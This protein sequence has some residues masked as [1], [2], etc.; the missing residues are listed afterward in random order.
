MIKKVKE[1]KIGS[2][3][4]GGSRPFALIAGVCVIE[5]EEHTMKIAAAL[6]E[7][8]GR[9]SVPLIFKASYDKAN[10]TS[11]SS[12]R[13]PGLGAGLRILED[14]KNELDVPVLTDC[15]REEDA[16]EVALM[17]DVI[18][19]PAF[20]CRQT[21]I[22]LAI[23]RTGRVVNVKKGQFLAPED[24][25]HIIKKIESTGNHNILLTER[26]IC[27]GYRNLIN[28]MR[29][30]PIMRGLGYPVVFDATH[31]VQLPGGGEGVT[32]GAREFIPYLARAAMGTGC[33]ALFME[34]HDNP[35]AALSDA[36]SVI[37]INKL[38]RLLET[39]KKIDRVVKDE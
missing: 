37:P 18:Q 39:L 16:P 35:A 13:G 32:G 8:C 28:D 38:S 21:D 9:L 11:I 33:D 15:H 17:A 4:L 10:R 27:F 3:T 29:A 5:S 34:V 2:I 25:G 23:A 30:I 6:K 31:S 19:I 12:Y 26:G 1:I 20:L 7:I 14:I 22:V 36:A 24:M